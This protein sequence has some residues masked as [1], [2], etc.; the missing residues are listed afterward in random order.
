MVTGTQ[1]TPWV[2]VDKHENL[3]ACGEG[4]RFVYPWDVPE[5]YA[6]FAAAGDDADEDA[7]EKLSEAVE[8]FLSR[9]TGEKSP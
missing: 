9:S 4:I 3:V 7:H 2:F 6:E 8:K 5:A 1:K